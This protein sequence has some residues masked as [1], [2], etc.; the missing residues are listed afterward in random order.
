MKGQEILVSLQEAGVSVVLDGEDI[1]ARP[2]LAV[3]PEVV[4]LLR[5]NKAEV[6]QA[7]EPVASEEEV[8]ELARELFGL[9]R[10]GSRHPDRQGLTARWSREF[11]YVS[12]RD[13]LDGAWHDLH[14]K[15]APE[16]ARWEARKR[17]ELWRAG[18]K[19]AY[20]LS[21][22]QMQKIWEADH[23]PRGEEGIV[24]EHPIEE[25]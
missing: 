17:K 2:T 13:P 11:G 15:D 19:R 6:V 23:P 4:A 16:W 1:V 24:E 18:N 14:W 3:T 21:A 7:L 22:P 8:F 25:A 12:I 20:E 5:E 9:E 10:G